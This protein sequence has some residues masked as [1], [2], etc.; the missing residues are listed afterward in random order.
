MRPMIDAH[1]DLAWNAVS[2][3]RDQLLDVTQL[4]AAEARMTGKG[5][6]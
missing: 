6:G 5:R 3:D 4:N 2:Y 1:L